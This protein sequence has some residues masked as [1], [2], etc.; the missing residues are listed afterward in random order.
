MR[1]HYQEKERAMFRKKVFV[2][3]L[4]MTVI[5]SISIQSKV[6]ANTYA[7][8]LVEYG[9]NNSVLREGETC[10]MSRPYN[11]EADQKV[12]ITIVAIDQRRVQLLDPGKLKIVK[13]KCPKNRECS[14]EKELNKL[15]A[16]ELRID[17]NI[18]INRRS[19][20]EFF[21]GMMNTSENWNIDYICHQYL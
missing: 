5:I 21:F 10:K 8:C 7:C 4:I 15:T 11:R 16:Q 14:V 19:E 6:L 9:L 17:K 20:G 13:L 1:S 3:I 2:K 12:N 18:T